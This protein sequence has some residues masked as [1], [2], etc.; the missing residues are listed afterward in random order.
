MSVA[1]RA[2]VRQLSLE[3]GVGPVV[4]NNG[5]DV[6][7]FAPLRPQGL[8]RVHRAAVGLQADHLTVRAGDRRPRGERQTD[9]DRAAGEL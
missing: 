7:P 6:E 5:D 4:E 1:L 9:A 2:D 3:D 8:H